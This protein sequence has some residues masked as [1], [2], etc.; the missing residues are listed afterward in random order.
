[1]NKIDLAKIAREEGLPL[2]LYA[3]G[4]ISATLYTDKIQTCI[5]DSLPQEDNPEP[6]DVSGVKV[7]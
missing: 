4:T 1:M 7:G 5:I 6:P 3:D 2:Y